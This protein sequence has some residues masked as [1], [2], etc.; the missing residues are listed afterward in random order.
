[1][2]E[3]IFNVFTDTDGDI[4]IDKFFAYRYSSF[5]SVYTIPCVCDVEKTLENLLM[6]FSLDS[7][8]I[9]LTFERASKEDFAKV[10]YNRSVYLVEVQPYMLVVLSSSKM[11]IYYS[12]NRFD[13][14]DLVKV[15]GMI[16]KS[17]KE[18]SGLE[19][20]LYLLSFE[21]SDYCIKK[22]DFEQV[23][24]D[25]DK[26]YNVDFKKF[27]EKVKEFLQSDS[28]SGIV[29]LYGEAG[30]GKSLYLRYLVSNLQKRFILIPPKLY[31]HLSSINLYLYLRGLEGSVLILEDC[32]SMII[33]HIKNSPISEFLS[34]AE[35]LLGNYVYK[36]LCTITAKEHQINF[37]YLIK[38]SEIL[39][40]S[41][42]PLTLSRA[43]D[44]IKELGI[45][46][47]IDKPIA[48]RQ[49][50]KNKDIKKRKLGFNL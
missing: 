49:I 7:N 12:A 25:I 3:S 24:Q 39:K 6:N 20:G 43:R 35:G 23:D 21:D 38:A 50:F 18:D 19:S 33:G 2:K 9:L 8:A 1:M 42:E 29:L 28:R 22:V 34:F 26:F 10:D 31:S 13:R 14:T 40:Y 11:E 5:A 17:G 44:L 46:K 37:S 27:N 16:V 4:S 15:H 30:T 32:S 36:I 41:F 48:L 45:Q 47:Q